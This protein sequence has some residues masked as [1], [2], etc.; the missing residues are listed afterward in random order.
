MICT[1]VEYCSLQKPLKEPKGALATD[2]LG[3]HNVWMILQFQIETLNFN[4]LYY[5][6]FEEVEKVHTCCKFQRHAKIA[7]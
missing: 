6:V 7:H 5:S 4:I 3:A 2:F 1:L